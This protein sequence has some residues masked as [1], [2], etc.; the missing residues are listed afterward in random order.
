[1]LIDHYTDEF[2][3]SGS[4]H[5]PG[6][7]DNYLHTFEMDDGELPDLV[8]TLTFDLTVDHDLEKS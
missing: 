2:T 8:G 7:D 6:V 5:S 1:V 4:F 3:P